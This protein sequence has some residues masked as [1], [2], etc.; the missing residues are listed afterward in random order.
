[1]SADAVFEEGQPT[2]GG[3]PVSWPWFGGRPGLTGHGFA[4]LRFWELTGAIDSSEGVELRFRL[5]GGGD[6][7]WPHAFVLPPTVKMGEVDFDREVDRVYLS[8]GAVQVVDKTWKRTLEVGKSG[9]RATVVWNGIRG[10]K[11]PGALPTCRMKPIRAS[12]A[13]RL[14]TPGRMS[15]RSNLTRP[16]ASLR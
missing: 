16:T 11:N 5:R 4:R 2:R 8:E 9:S 6:F 13:S 3:I 10:S 7:G 1:M 12:C 15:S 14:P